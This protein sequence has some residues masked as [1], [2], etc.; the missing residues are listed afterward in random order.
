MAA[1]DIP[2]NVSPEATFIKDF[3]FIINKKGKN[4]AVDLNGNYGNKRVISSVSQTDWK[5]TR[6]LLREALRDMGVNDKDIMLILEILDN[7][8]DIILENI[9]IG[10]GTGNGSNNNNDNG[11]VGGPEGVEQNRQR[12]RAIKEY[13]MSSIRNTKESNPNLTYEQWRQILTTKFLTLQNIVNRYYPDMWESLKFTIGVKTILNIEDI[14]TPFIGIILG[15]PGTSKTLGV[16]RLDDWLETDRTDDF[17]PAS[18]VTH[19]AALTHKDI[20]DVDMLPQI[21]DKMLSTPE[22]SPLF[23]AP[24]DEIRAQF[25]LI[26][27]SGRWSRTLD[28]L[29]SSR[30]AWLQRQIH[31]CLGWRSSRDSR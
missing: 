18:L 30:S 15:P 19:S 16:T 2:L 26:K 14:S 9:S 3:R 11:Q 6:T 21:Q 8:S 31:V 22:L 7:N 24:D 28:K 12:Q 17:T 25:G 5:K 27:Q 1:K 10:D 4:L 23:T 20:A 29:R 13:I